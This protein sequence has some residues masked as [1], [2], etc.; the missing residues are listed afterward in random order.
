MTEEFWPDQS[1][2]S[3]LLTD[4]LQSVS[5]KLEGMTT[6]FL[7]KHGLLKIES[8]P[9]QRYLEI[10]EKAYNM[11]RVREGLSYD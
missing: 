7:D 8:W 10:E 5:A 6:K 2:T 1:K 9:Y 3:Y 4:T 11:K